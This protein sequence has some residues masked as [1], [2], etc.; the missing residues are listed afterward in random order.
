MLIAEIGNCHFGDFSVAKQMVLAAHNA[1]ADLIKGQA[2]RA[3]DIKSGSMPEAFYKKCAFSVE[4]YLE[5]I[6]YARDLGNDMFFSIFSEGME[7]IAAKQKWRKVAG[8]QTRKGLLTMADDADNLVISV[9]ITVSVPRFKKAAVLHVSDYITTM[10]HLWQIQ[11][12]TSYLGQQAGYSD[13]T[14]GIRNCLIAAREM[15]ATVIEKHFTLQKDMKW[16]GETFR[17]TVHGATPA[18]FQKLAKELSK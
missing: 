9:P 11:A 12:L 7:A 18:E 3:E 16:N 6:D 15:G 17:D 2:F 5:L 1:G 4:Q 13:H 10:P 8:A 14:I